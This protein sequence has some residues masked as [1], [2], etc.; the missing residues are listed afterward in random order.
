MFIASLAN[1]MEFSSRLTGHAFELVESNG[2]HHGRKHF[3]LYNP[4]YDGIGKRSTHQETKDLLVSCVKND[5]QALCF[6]GSRK[7]AELVTLWA[8]ED[9]RRTSAQ[10]ADAICAYRAG[11]LHEDRSAIEIGLKDETRK[12][13]VSTNA[14]ELS[15]DIGS[16][17]AVI[18]SGYPGTMVSTWQQAGRAGRKGDISLA[19]LVAQANP[20]DQYF[21]NHPE[22]FFSRSHEHAIV[23]TGNPYIISGH[24]LCAAA[25]LTLREDEDRVFF[26]DT[27]PHLLPELASTDLVRKTALGGGCIQAGAGLPAWSAL[28][29]Y[30][31]KHSGSC[32]MAGCWRPWTGRRHTGKHIN[33]RFSFI[34]VRCITSKRWIW[35]LISGA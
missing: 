16:R 10:L 5:L 15:I 30:P 8:R 34:R 26:G 20:F 33:V 25:E 1:P 23:D 35:K 24:L 14:L 18:I 3:V 7:A 22:S 29:A 19:L 12:G 2:S 32:V 31:E 13:V 4:L 21:M 17:D 6:T 9:A 11:Y 27:F 28:G